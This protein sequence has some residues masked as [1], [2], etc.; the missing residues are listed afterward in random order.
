LIV[1]CKQCEELIFFKDDRAG[2]TAPCTVCRAPIF[3]P[4]PKKEGEPPRPAENYKAVEVP[5]DDPI[6]EPTLSLPQSDEVSEPPNPVPKSANPHD[7]QRGLRPR[8]D[9]VLELKN[10][11]ILSIQQPQPSKKLQAVMCPYCN[12]LVDLPEHSN[13]QRITCSRCSKTLSLHKSERG[14]RAA[15]PMEI[16]DQ[17]FIFLDRDDCVCGMCKKR[18]VVS[19]PSEKKM[20]CPKCG[21]KIAIPSSIA[22]PGCNSQ[23]VPLKIPRKPLITSSLIGDEKGPFY[24]CN[25]CGNKWAIEFPGIE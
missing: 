8:A 21:S 25:S 10:S 20:H 24:Q 19:N 3:L 1:K 9:V 4:P 18:V 22:C 11:D 6:S 5:A 17:P 15:P 16:N 2:E 13:I 23:D 14:V 12:A 7:S